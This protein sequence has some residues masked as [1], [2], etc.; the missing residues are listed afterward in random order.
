M[1]AK[2]I[3]DIEIFKVVNRAISESDD[4]EI[5]ATH[6]SQLLTGALEI[7]GSSIFVLNPETNELEILASFG[8]SMS[9][10]NKGPLLARKS[11]AR[12]MQGE[13]IVIN[14]IE[15]AQELQ[16]PEE[17]K[18][19]GI[20]SVVSIP[21]RFYAKVIGEMRLYHFRPWD[22]SQRDLDSLRLLA[23]NIGLAMMYMRLLNALQT[24]RQTV[25]DIHSVW[26][27]PIKG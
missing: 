17:A 3:I 6:L 9:Y 14:N 7:K 20:A 12:P 13:T 22:L 5:M 25:G 10:L 21:I 11:L 26:L 23:E 15:S 27:D 8:L 4:L 19:E 18:K 2:D 16:Y 1:G 24:I